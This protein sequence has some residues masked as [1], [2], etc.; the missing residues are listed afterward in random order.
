[1]I[2]TGVKIRIKSGE[3]KTHLNLIYMK[4][5]QKIHAMYIIITKFGNHRSFPVQD[6]S[7]QQSLV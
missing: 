5:P 1:M 6:H 2:I 3:D 4:S 7:S